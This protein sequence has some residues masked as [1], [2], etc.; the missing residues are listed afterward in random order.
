MFEFEGTVTS[1]DAEWISLD[2]TAFYPGGGGQMNDLGKICGLDVTEVKVKGDEIYH[3]VPG[4]SIRINDKV[5]CSVDWER[6]YDMML[7]HTAEHLLFGSL[8]REVPDI[9]IVKIFISQESKYVVVDRDVEWDVIGRAQNSVNKAVNDNMSVSKI[10]MSRDDPEMKDIRAK[11]ERIDGEYITVVEIGDADIA[12]CSGIHVRETGEIGCL[13]VDRKVSAGKDGYAIHF[14]VGNDALRRSMELA[15]DCLRIADVL[16]A[17]TDDVVKAV[18]NVKHELETGTKQLR[19]AMKRLLNDMQ[20]LTI[21]NIPVYSGIFE[22]NDR[23]AV[24]D[25]AEKIRSEGGIAVLLMVGDTLSVIMSSGAKGVDCSVILK[26]V[27]TKAGGRGGGKRDFAQGGVA[28]VS[29]S[30]TI[31][32]DIV[33]ILKSVLKQEV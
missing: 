32:K 10:T 27:L 14:R 13:I 5:W 21:C 33:R 30:D 1:A 31:H 17:K 9:E 19:S 12:A 3:K 11:M 24:T 8:K 6:R 28:D 4:H 23:T 2:I 25:A 22:T 20:P 16:G 26:E 29:L 18:S 15:N 7:G